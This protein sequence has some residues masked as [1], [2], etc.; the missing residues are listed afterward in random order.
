MVPIFHHNAIDIL[1]LACLTA[2]VPFA[3][4]AP[5]EVDVRTART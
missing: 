2:I 4:R 5:E 1:S 3:F